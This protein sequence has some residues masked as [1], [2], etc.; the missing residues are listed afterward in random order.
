MKISIALCTYNGEKFLSE[1]LESFI[2]QTRLPDEL[3][4]GDDCS[5]DATIRLITDFAKTSPFPVRVK[6]NEK[7]LGSTKNF[8]HTILNCTSEI[9]LLSDQDDVWL[10][11]KIEHFE[12]L[13][14]ENEQIG[15][16][17]TNA[18]VVRENLLPYGK[19]LWD[20]VFEIEE[21]QKNFLNVLMRRNVVTGATMGFRAKF[22]KLFSPIPTDI[23]NTIHDGWISLVIAANSNVMFVDEC[24]IK[25]RQHA[26]Q[27]LGIDWN[28][29]NRDRSDLYKNSI[30]F[31][32]NE[33]E[34]IKLMADVLGNYP[35]FQTEKIQSLKDEIISTNL[36]EKAEILNHYKFRSQLEDGKL[37]RLLPILSELKTG[38]YAR[39]SKGWK[40]ALKDLFESKI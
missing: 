2:N 6:V 19:K 27:Q 36:E 20:F 13:F 11:N 16:I 23:P 17:F 22:A 28:H 14:S 38:R 25:Y 26:N 4:V 33:L 12:T 32:Q 31:H 30:I 34:R 10:P 37:K 18:E 21:R 8:E 24:L 1:Q 40:S 3:V 9:I 39:F 29:R 7:N 5:S 15:M 35:Q